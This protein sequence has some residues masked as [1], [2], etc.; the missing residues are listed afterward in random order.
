MLTESF[1]QRARAFSRN[2]EG[3]KALACMQEAIALAPQDC[4]ALNT[5]GM[6]LDCLGRHGEALADYER[7]LTID[8]RFADAINNRGIHYARAGRF[9]EALACYERSSRRASR[10]RHTITVAR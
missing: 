1:V 2:G 3:E 6:I 8:P 4:H 5:R 7:V 10:S 9:E